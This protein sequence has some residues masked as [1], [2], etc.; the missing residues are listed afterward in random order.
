MTVLIGEFRESAILRYFKAPDATYGDL[1]DAAF[2]LH[3]HTTRECE[4]V[5]LTNANLD[6]V[7][8]L[9]NPAARREIISA[10]RQLGFQSAFW[11]RSRKGKWHLFYFMKPGDGH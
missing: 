5:A 6:V 10:L 7:R 3:P 11:R 2:V 1:Y 4:L 8:I 9:G